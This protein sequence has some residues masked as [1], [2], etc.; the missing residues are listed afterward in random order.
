MSMSPER[1]RATLARCSTS[2]VADV[3]KPHGSENLMMR[4]V[5]ARGALA[6]PLFG[7][8]RTL[9]FLPSRAD[10]KA[11]VPNVRTQAI[12]TVGENEVLVFDAAC[13]PRSSVLGDMM[14]ARLVQRRAAGVITDG[15]MRDIDAILALGVPIF[16]AHLAPAPTAAPWMA[17][18]KDVTIQCG[19]V[20][21]QPGDW[22]FG[23][24]DGVIVIPG[25]LLEFVVEQGEA[26]LR[27]EEFCRKL[28]DRGHSLT[29]AFPM[30][31]ALQPH[32]EKYLQTGELPPESVVGTPPA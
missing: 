26:L 20:L 3:L 11:P 18:E 27:K 17:W 30:P 32:F 5:S 31:A 14:A 16:C 23:D 22:V 21:V 9:R 1:I 29:Q 28:L 2:L 6:K 15:A 8:V 19:G 24:T 7:L 4:G 10:V 12:D 13:C 25:S